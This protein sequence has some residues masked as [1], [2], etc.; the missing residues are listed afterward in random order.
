MRTSI[1]PYEPLVF[2]YFAAHFTKVSDVGASML[3]HVFGAYFGLMVSYVLQ[4]NGT[5]EKQSTPN[6]SDNFLVIGTVH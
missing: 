5:S 4:R 1:T 2:Y 6:T 3:V